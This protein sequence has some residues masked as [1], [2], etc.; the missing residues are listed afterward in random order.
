MSEIEISHKG[1]NKYRVI[2]GSWQHEVEE[3]ARV[4]EEIWN[5]IWEAKQKTK[6]AQKDIE[7][8]QKT[9]KFK[10]G[11]SKNVD[12]EKLKDHSYFGLPSPSK[13]EFKKI[14][15]GP[16]ENDSKYNPDLRFFDRLIQSKKSKKIDE[17]ES[18]FKHDYNCWLDEKK[19]I[20]KSNND[21]EK[22]YKKEVQEWEKSKEKFLKTQTETNNHIEDQKKNYFDKKPDSILFYCEKVLINSQY[23]E[24]FPKDFDLDY[25]PNNRIL[26][27]DYSLPDIESVPTL[28]ELKFIQTKN[29]FRESHLSDTALRKLYDDLLYQIVLRSIRE[30]YK[31]DIVDSLESIVFNGWVNSTDRATGIKV[32]SCIL[33]IQTSKEEFLKINLLKVDPK[34]CFRNLK[35]VGSSKLYNLTPIA[36]IISIDKEDKRFISSYD[37]SDDLDESY[38]LALMDWED[39]EHLIRELFEKEFSEG[40]GDVK[41][42]RASR[43]G[44]VDAVAFDPDI[45][46]GGKIVIQ[47]KRYVK[48]RK[49]VV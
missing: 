21:L 25:N 17:A 28:K 44:G 42:T 36:P 15:R 24:Y 49:S 5:N 1:L 20:E 37:V 18:R 45:I 29:E 27:V 38:N 19:S 39:F 9:L 26:V 34:I 16:K 47:A 7:L 41:V 22:N 43:D 10:Y 13:P 12:W 6:K 46:R 3:K 4:Q 31:A 2:R 40:G 48:D 23:P 35:G 14:P 8:L 32:N 11:S 33:S 30:L